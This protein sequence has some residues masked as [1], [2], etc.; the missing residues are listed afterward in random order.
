M[1]TLEA[2]HLLCTCPPRPSHECPPVS[3]VPCQQTRASRVHP[4]CA[5]AHAHTHTHSLCGTH[6]L[7][8]TPSHTPPPPA[9]SRRLIHRCSTHAHSLPCVCTSRTHTRM[10]S[11]HRFSS[12]VSRKHTLCQ[13]CSSAEISPCGICHCVLGLPG[14]SLPPLPPALPVVAF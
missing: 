14:L 1:V 4:M 13:E 3:A 6:R 10:H 7:R 9:F 5:R 12:C 8:H 11:H 2:H